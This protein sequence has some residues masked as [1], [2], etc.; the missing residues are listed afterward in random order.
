MSEPRNH[1][2]LWRQGAPD[3]G[4]GHSVMTIKTELELQFV[5]DVVSLALYTPPG[6][7]FM[8]Q[9]VEQVRPSTSHGVFYF[10]SSIE[11]N[12]S[13]LDFVLASLDRPRQTKD[14][15]KQL[16]LPDGRILHLFDANS[17]ASS[18]S[19]E[20]EVAAAASQGW[21]FVQ[22]ADRINRPIPDYAFGLHRNEADQKKNGTWPYLARLI[23]ANY[24]A[25]FASLQTRLLPKWWSFNSTAFAKLKA[26]RAQAKPQRGG[27]SVA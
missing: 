18:A 21:V 14:A 20:D 6:T 3:R 8:G 19:L 12:V 1:Q 2:P 4:S 11:A 16:T 10:T 27:P 13:L 22:G 9:E 17:T 15:V 5:A 23:V 24:T 26:A 25:N 7:L